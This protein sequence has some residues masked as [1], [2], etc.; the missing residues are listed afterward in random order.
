[1]QRQKDN[2]RKTIL[3]VARN[4]FF[5]N[6]FKNTSMRTIANKS[7]VGLSNIYNYFQNKDEI[8]GVVLNPLLQALN[9]MLDEHNKPDHISTDFFTMDKYWLSYVDVYVDLIFKYKEE[10]KLLLF[11]SHGSCLENFRDEYIDKNTGI[12]LEY[13]QKM[14]EKYPWVNINISEFFLRTMSSWWLSII[15][16]I[17]LHNLRHKETEQFFT[18]FLEFGTAGWKK[19][20]RV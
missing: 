20:M 6:G 15:G 9:G 13:L 19:I 18:E 4:E 12:G 8:L 16:E 7:D 11:K 14:K 1:M 5:T 17:V 2:I 3:N 10:F